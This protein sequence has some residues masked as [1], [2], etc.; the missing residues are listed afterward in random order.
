MER[1]LLTAEERR[2]LC[3]SRPRVKVVKKCHQ[4]R[5][6][7]LKFK[8]ESTHI[9]NTPYYKSLEQLAK[10]ANERMT[11]LSK[12]SHEEGCR[13]LRTLTE[14]NQLLAAS[15][16]NSL[17]TGTLRFRQDA[18]ESPTASTKCKLESL[19][20]YSPNSVEV[21]RKVANRKSGKQLFKYF[22]HK[23]IRIT[24][25]TYITAAGKVIRKS[26]ISLRLKNS[27]VSGH[28]G[29]S[30]PL[31]GRT[32]KRQRN[33]S[34]SSSS[35]KPLIPRAKAQQKQLTATI[36][37]ATPADSQQG[38]FR[39]IAPNV[40]R[41]STPIQTPRPAIPVVDLT[42][43]SS[44]SGGIINPR[45]RKQFRYLSKSLKSQIRPGG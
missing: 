9:A 27:Q 39:V 42:K 43:L 45:A 40:V 11:W 8:M 1:D 2:K 4:S 22:G 24:P 31:L 44:S 26:D 14:I 33:F 7:L 13:V 36:R 15:L 35:D 12:L 34:S 25:S 5:D 38:K 28:Q 18:L 16:R 10:S 19:L 30:K 6:A 20:L 17:I 37:L 23:I 29:P 3:D 41:S 21:F 32:L